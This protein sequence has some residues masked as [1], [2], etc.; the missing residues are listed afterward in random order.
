M[1]NEIIQWVVVYSNY[2]IIQY[3][4]QPKRPI[5]FTLQLTTAKYQLFFSQTA[6]SPHNPAKIFNCSPKPNPFKNHIQLITSPA[7]AVPNSKN[8]PK[9]LIIYVVIPINND[10]NSTSKHQKLILKKEKY[11]VYHKNTNYLMN[12]QYVKLCERIKQCL[13]FIIGTNKIQLLLKIKSIRLYI[14]K[15]Q[16]LQNT[17]WSVLQGHANNDK[18]IKH[19]SVLLNMA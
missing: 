17:W 7:I 19:V 12:V 6:I 4:C 9:L 11:I 10:Q 2:N 14:A 18:T 13:F 1:N 15:I 8:Q 3:K 16:L 5:A